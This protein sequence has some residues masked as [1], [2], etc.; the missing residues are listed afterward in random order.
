MDVGFVGSQARDAVSPTGLSA[1]AVQIPAVTAPRVGDGLAVVDTKASF[2][3]G[4]AAFTGDLSKASVVVNPL[5]AIALRTPTEQAIT[6]TGGIY[7]GLPV[8]TSYAMPVGRIFIVD[9]SRVIAYVGDADVQLAS[10]GEMMMDDGTGV[11][12]S[13]G[14]AFL[15][16]ESKLALKGTQYVDWDFVPGAAVEVALTA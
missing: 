14:V 15:F 7:G 11:N 10:Q 16:Q 6:A 13:T 9:A 12:T 5:T 3:A 8:I 2:D 1:V 4:V